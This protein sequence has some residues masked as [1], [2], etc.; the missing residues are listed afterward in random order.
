MGRSPSH[1]G[2]APAHLTVLP[3]GATGGPA[4]LD[5]LEDERTTIEPAPPPVSDDAPTPIA[6]SNSMDEQWEDGTTVAESGEKR[7]LVDEP[8]VED[9]ARPLPPLQLVQGQLVQQQGTATGAAD[10]RAFAKLHVVAGSDQGRVFD[11]RPGKELSVGRA[12]DNDVCLTDIAVSRRHLELFWDGDGWVLR[13][14]GSGNG[15]LINERIEDGRCQLRD[16]DRIEIGNTVFRFDH[17]PSATKPTVTGW[18][19]QEEEAST[20]AGKQTGRPASSTPAPMP[21]A[22]PRPNSVTA[23][24]ADRRPPRPGTPERAKR[25]SQT[26]EPP[27]PATVRGMPVVE[28]RRQDGDARREA[29]HPAP[30]EG[31]P[32][33]APPQFLAGGSGSGAAAAP[34]G[35]PAPVA[36]IFGAGARPATTTALVEPRIYPQAAYPFVVAPDNRRKHLLIGAGVAALLAII[37]IGAMIGGDEAPGPAAKVVASDA[38]GGSGSAKLPTPATDKQPAVVDD[39]QPPAPAIDDPLPPTPPAPAVVNDQPPPTPPPAPAVVNDQPPPAPAVVN[40]QPPPAPPPV[41]IVEDKP[42]LA[43]AIVKQP[44]KPPVRPKVTP[45]VRPKVTPRVAVQ[46]DDLLEKPKPAVKGL[47]GAEKKADGLYRAK[48]WKGAAALLRDAA[49][50]ASDSDA[51]RLKGLAADYENIGNNLSTGATLAKAK[52]TDA[53][54]ALKKA[55]SADRRAGGAHQQAIRESVAKVAPSAAAAYMAKQNYPAAKLA[56][57]DAVN[58]GAGSNATVGNVRSSLERKAGEF[59][60]SAQKLL[61]D[62]PE[63]A[64]TILRNIMKIVPADS[65]WYGKA[66]KLLN[67]RKPASA[68]EDE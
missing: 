53:L 19:Q 30:A 33:V 60:A 56:A 57:D 68:D 64:K 55:L 49:D 18:G 2:R 40:D 4:G 32:V 13:D 22:R 45:P 36:A 26:P 67:Q 61:K 44:V 34:L 14:R 24:A 66:Y 63:E 10:P 21:D 39:Q 7:T 6:A 15:T 3:G 28:M 25:P 5:D 9:Q 62:K 37:G 42:P 8:T 51:K 52:P 65:P 1:I 35:T 46:N 20:V 50:D 48:D 58:V 16:G 38:G 27:R 11:L 23:A 54:G 47:A 29:G 17:P 59:F 43:P 41:P 12:V 31:V